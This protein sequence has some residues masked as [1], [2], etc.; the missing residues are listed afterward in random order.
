MAGPETFS[1]EHVRALAGRVVGTGTREIRAS[2]VNH[3]QAADVPIAVPRLER[4]AHMPI[5]VVHGTADPLFP[6]EHGRAL[7]HV[8]PSARVFELAGMG[9]QLHRASS[10]PR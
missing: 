4:L 7:V 1:D 2:L 8:I 3:F 9:R 5:L 6:L 10:G